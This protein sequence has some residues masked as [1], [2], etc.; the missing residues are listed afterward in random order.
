MGTDDLFKKRKEA[1]KKRQIETREPKPDSFFIATEGEK[2]E[3]QY[4][5]SI[6]EAI[7]EKSGGNIDIRV[8]GLGRGTT[9][10]VKEA[11]LLLSKSPY[12]Y[13]HAWVVF[14]KD[15]YED[16][17]EAVSLAEKNGFRVA[18]SNQ[19]FEY[20]LFLHF[21]FSDSA[22]HRAD[23]AEKLDQLFRDRGIREEGYEKNLPDLYD[24]LSQYGS[25]S[26][27]TGQA[28]ALLKAYGDKPPSKCD[29]CT[30]VFQ[31]IESL[32][33]FM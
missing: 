31:L 21:E 22:L 23:W 19:A 17:D 9:A 16:F 1:K 27:A 32:R 2:T 12:M 7:T 15:D 26:F 6:A 3:P 28:K 10:L 33:R 14:D 8:V 20:W 5:R 4:F 18:W 30:T 29:P 13:Q 11:A 24:I 25:E